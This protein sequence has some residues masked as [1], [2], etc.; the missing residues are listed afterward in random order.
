M[1]R[2]QFDNLFKSVSDFFGT[3]ANSD[4]VRILG[5]LIQ[6]EELDVNDIH[7]K[8]HIS[9]S[10]V[11]QHLKL[12]KL[13]E[14]VTERREGKHVF[15]SIKDERIS[16]VLESAFQFQMMKLNDTEIVMKIQEIIT[17]LHATELAGNENE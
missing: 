8:L 1:N 13:N 5:L 11:S 15:Y 17:I 14:L 16:N 2:E 7:D 10:R 3:L 12:L 9:Q 4:R 6:Y